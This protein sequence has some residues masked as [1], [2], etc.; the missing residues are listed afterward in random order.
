MI[1]AHEAN[2]TTPTGRQ[3]SSNQKKEKKRADQRQHK[4]GRK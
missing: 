3:A 1:Y 4:T 2:K